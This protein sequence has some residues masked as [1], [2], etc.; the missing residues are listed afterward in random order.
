MT[1]SPLDNIVYP[2]AGA[3]GAL[4]LILFIIC[5]ICCVTKKK[6]PRREN[7]TPQGEAILKCGVRMLGEK[8]E[9][10]SSIPSLVGGINKCQ[11]KGQN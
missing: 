4:S 9:I 10:S 1:S 2:A 5:V 6:T 7:A 3:V 11:A 8:T